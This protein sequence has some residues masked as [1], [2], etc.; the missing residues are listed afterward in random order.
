MVEQDVDILVP[1]SQLMTAG[2]TDSVRQSE[3]VRCS[4]TYVSADAGSLT[5]GKYLADL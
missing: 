2:R 5:S 4:R 1:S 3:S